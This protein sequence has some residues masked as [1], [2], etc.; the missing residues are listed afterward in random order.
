MIAL[1]E[2]LNVKHFTGGESVSLG[3]SISGIVFVFRGVELTAEG[4]G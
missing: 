1:A 3:F 4:S 2:K